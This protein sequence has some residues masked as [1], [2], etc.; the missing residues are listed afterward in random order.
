[1]VMTAKL[2]RMPPISKFRRLRTKEKRKL[3]KQLRRRIN[4]QKNLIKRLLM[5]LLMLQR[6]ANRLKRLHLAIHRVVDLPQRLA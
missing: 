1:M 4:L 5:L 6:R 2:P 3:R